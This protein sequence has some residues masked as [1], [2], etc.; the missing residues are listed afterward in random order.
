M[1]R[2]SQS[3]PCLSR[4]QRRSPVVA[5]RPR[6][7]EANDE[8]QQVCGRRTGGGGGASSRSTCRCG[9]R[10]TRQCGR[11]QGSRDAADDRVTVKEK[12]ARVLLLLRTMHLA[13]YN[14]NGGVVNI[15]SFYPSCNILLSL[16]YYTT[17]QYH[18]QVLK[19]TLL[20]ILLAIFIIGYLIITKCKHH[21][22]NTG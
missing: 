12:S 3:I 4:G 5:H 11:S 16:V 10:V 2:G 14:K 19:R 18:R 21:S 1:T 20:Y 9:R 8:L 13:K 6:G 17:K 15:R 7:K 22:I